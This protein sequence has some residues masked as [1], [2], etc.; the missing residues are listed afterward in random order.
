MTTLLVYFEPS[1]LVDFI[2]FIAHMAHK[3]GVRCFRISLL[4]Q[5]PNNVQEPMRDVVDQVIAPLTNHVTALLA[6][7]ITG[8]DDK[9]TRLET[10]KEFLNFLNS[11]M[12]TRLGG[13][14]VSESEDLKSTS[15]RQ[16]D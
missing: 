1:E 3:I 6:Q 8:T 9:V 14:L 2:K 13:I 10:K 16:V 12:T 5:L 7:P 11:I 15:P 4:I